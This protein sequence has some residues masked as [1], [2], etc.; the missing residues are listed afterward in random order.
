LKKLFAITLLSIYLFNLTGY[1]VL[2]QFLEYRSDKQLLARI[3]NARFNE[4]RLLEI[5]VPLQ[6][7]YTTDWKDYERY[8]G[9]IEIAGI[10]YNYV[11][12]KL[13]GDTLYLLCL[14]NE[15]KTQIHIVKNE[16]A[17]K[18]ND[19]PAGKGSQNNL[20]K[21]VNTLCEYSQALTQF[22]F[23]FPVSPNPGKCLFVSVHFDQ[24][25]A[26]ENWQPPESI[27]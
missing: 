3:D 23:S 11:K 19:I 21:K 15:N 16:Y 22:S 7:P 27:S 6:L 1:T 13:S 14:P 18:V 25:P 5:K 10:H 26:K 24:E 17:G 8:D 2:F 20:G 9:E 4:Q 12:R